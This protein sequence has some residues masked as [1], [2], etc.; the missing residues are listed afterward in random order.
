MEL[1]NL[2]NGR[3]NSL[4]LLYDEVGNSVHGGAILVYVLLVSW[5]FLWDL[6]L[7]WHV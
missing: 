7:L 5:H 1:C 6:V 4:P 3:V 2:E